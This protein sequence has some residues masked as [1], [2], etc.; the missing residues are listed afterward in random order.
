MTVAV[1]EPKTRKARVV[2]TA[3]QKK[4]SALRRDAAILE[5]I[6]M[7]S[8]DPAG[9]LATA[10]KF[11]AL[12]NGLAPAQVKQSVF[13]LTEAEWQAVEAYFM[14]GDFRANLLKVTTERKLKAIVS[15]AA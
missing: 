13:K 2:A 4:A 7:N 14:A 8:T 10:A 6:A 5:R 1:A 3:D 15:P 9:T 11:R 12:A